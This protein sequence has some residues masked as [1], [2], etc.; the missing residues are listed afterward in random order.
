MACK[1]RNDV[2]RDVN[3]RFTAEDA[4]IKVKHLYAPLRPDERLGEVARL[5]W[6][7]VPGLGQPVDCVGEGLPQGAGLEPQLVAG[8]GVIAPGIAVD[9][10]DALGTPGQP[11]P[12]PTLHEVC[13]PAEGGKKPRREGHEPDAPA[14]EVAER[15]D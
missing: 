6:G 11:C 8:L 12:H 7:E 10:P 2:V 1:A 5:A 4:R 3:W 13:R 14:G 9:D 15:A